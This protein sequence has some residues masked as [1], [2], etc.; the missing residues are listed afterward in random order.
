MPI[1]SVA[2]QPSSCPECGLHPQPPSRPVR[3]EGGRGLQMVRGG[4]EGS[5]LL[6]PS[7]PLLIYSLPPPGHTHSTPTRGR[8]RGAHPPPWEEIYQH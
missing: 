7:L 8:E 3:Q 4:K 1:C 6:P 5:L 2:A